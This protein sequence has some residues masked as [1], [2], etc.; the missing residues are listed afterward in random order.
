MRLC[1]INCLQSTPLGGKNT[2]KDLEEALFAIE[3]QSA[4]ISQYKTEIT[5]L[6]G[7]CRGRDIVAGNNNTAK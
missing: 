6:H 7:E 5:R 4:E 2:S 3:R 1:V